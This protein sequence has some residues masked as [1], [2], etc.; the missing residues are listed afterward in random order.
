MDNEF[1]YLNKRAG[2]HRQMARQATGADAR[3]AH[4]AT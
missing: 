1:L 2:F 3:R 4:G